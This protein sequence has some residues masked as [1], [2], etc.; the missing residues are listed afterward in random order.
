MHK[1]QSPSQR[2]ATRFVAALYSD[3]DYPDGA[4]SGLQSVS[5]FGG[6][7]TVGVNQ[8]KVLRF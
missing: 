8:Q 5:S 4:D 7:A 1:V 2:K 6:P 3:A